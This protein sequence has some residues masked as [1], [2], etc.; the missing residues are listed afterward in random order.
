MT[1]KEVIIE[2]GDAKSFLEPV[3][4]YIRTLDP[5]TGKPAAGNEDAKR[6]LNLCKS[7]TGVLPFERDIPYNISRIEK[8][9]AYL[10]PLLRSEASLHTLLHRAKQEIE[11]YNQGSATTQT[12]YPKSHPG[13]ERREG[14]YVLSTKAVLKG[15]YADFHEIFS[16]AKEVVIHNLR[17]EISRGI[18]G[19][20]LKQMEMRIEQGFTGGIDGLKI[21]FDAK[22]SDL[23]YAAR[24]GQVE[25][26]RDFL[27][28]MAKTFITAFLRNNFYDLY[29]RISD[30]AKED[31]YT[32]IFRLAK[33]CTDIKAVD[34][35]AGITPYFDGDGNIKLKAR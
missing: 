32:F 23:L 10:E 14:D 2:G 35:E 15:K 6:K 21:Y 22:H 11:F 28:R 33:K 13:P 16:D 17:D 19:E 27:F 29:K 20:R 24:E 12:P 9:L 5:R 4:G 18:L 25:A 8:I 34:P 31:L 1:E 30:K 3:L 7:I 26:Q